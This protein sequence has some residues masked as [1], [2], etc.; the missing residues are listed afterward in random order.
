MFPTLP[1]SVNEFPKID[2]SYII[3][4]RDLDKVETD[5]LF[6]HT[7]LIRSGELMLGPPM[8]EKPEYDSYTKQALSRSRKQ[9]DSTE[10]KEIEDS[11]F[12]G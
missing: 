2:H 4:L 8:G 1:S 7:R 5:I 3:I 6:E 9:Y 12:K 10:R 11:E